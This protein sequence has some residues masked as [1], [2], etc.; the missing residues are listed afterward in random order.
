MVFFWIVIKGFRYILFIL[1]SIHRLSEIQRL[2]V[3]LW[4]PGL[5]HFLFFLFPF[6]PPLFLHLKPCFVS[7]SYDSSYLSHQ[8][9]Y[10]SLCL[11]DT[12]GGHRASALN[13]RT[14]ITTLGTLGSFSSSCFALGTVSDD[15]FDHFLF[16]FIIWSSYDHYA[17]SLL[18]KVCRF[19]LTNCLWQLVLCRLTLLFRNSD[20]AHLIFYFARSFCHSLTAI[21]TSYLQVTTMREQIL[22]SFAFV[23]VFVSCRLVPV[24]WSGGPFSC[25]AIE[26][27]V[28]SSQIQIFRGAIEAFFMH[29]MC[30]LPMV[31]AR[32]SVFLLLSIKFMLFDCALHSFFRF[33]AFRY[34]IFDIR[35]FFCR[36]FDQLEAKKMA[37]RIFCKVELG[38]SPT[39][40]PQ[41]ALPSAFPSRLFHC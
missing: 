24:S 12:A 29:E 15:N 26:F 13:F 5:F 27:W 38:R 41:L 1:S 9:C 31:R 23:G 33:S 16:N 10:R 21:S 30:F 17:S 4:S 19:S 18:L 7:S 2:L 3:I 20:S 25:F 6:L 40:C 37:N 39:P 35:P 14:A 8:E 11:C 36:E 28:P 34:P 32:F 22:I